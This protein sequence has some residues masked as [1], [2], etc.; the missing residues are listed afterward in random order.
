MKR[1]IAGE[2]RQRKL[3]RNVLTI[4]NTAARLSMGP[5]AGNG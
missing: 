3:R 5:V 1:F 4:V 2:N